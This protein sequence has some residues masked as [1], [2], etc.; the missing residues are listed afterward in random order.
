MQPSNPYAP[1][2]ANLDPT[3]TVPLDEQI[4]AL[5]VSPAWKE[6]FK[7]IAHAGGPKLPHF[8]QLSKKER[9][10]AMRLNIL[11][12][13]FGPVYYAIKGMWKKGLVYF[14]LT[15]LVAIAVAL[16]L[17]YFGYERFIR[18]ATCSFGVWFGVKAN[19]DFYKKMVEGRN[20]WW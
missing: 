9:Q 1:P 5:A 16:T 15:L 19:T 17:D 7:A 13:I 3:S 6:R 2:T 18:A 14:L 8:K 20:G 12:F 10:K 4:D 11:A